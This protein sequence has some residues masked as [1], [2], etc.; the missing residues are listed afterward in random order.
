MEWGGR[1]R[2]PVSS[3]QGWA[4]ASTGAY[5]KAEQQLLASF[6]EPGAVVLDIGACFG[7][8]TMPLAVVAKAA[9]CR[10]ASFEPVP[11]NAEVLRLNIA[12]NGLGAV[13]DVHEIALGSMAGVASLNVESARGGNAAIDA[14]GDLEPPGPATVTT[15]VARLDDLD[16]VPV[17]RPV[18]KIDVEGYEMDVLEGAGRFIADFRPVIL[19]EF[20]PAWFSARRIPD[21]SLASWARQHRY[22]AYGVD[23]RRRSIA[24]D[25]RTVHLAPR[26]YPVPSACPL[27]LLPVEMATPKGIL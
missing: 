23:A 13:I 20:N 10:V 18:V 16:I 19:G 21:S 22:V 12:A 8:W 25:E 11:S 7:L 1:M 15:A 24:R 6:I 4:A 14:A 5:D 9:G 3:S 27:L 17:G 26:T 2:L